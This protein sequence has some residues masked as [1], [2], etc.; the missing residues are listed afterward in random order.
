MQL[1]FVEKASIRRDGSLVELVTLAVNEVP[2]QG[3]VDRVEERSRFMC[4]ARTAVSMK[5][6][7]YGGARQLHVIEPPPKVDSF[8]EGSA[9]RILID[10][11]CVNDMRAKPTADPSNYA[12]A[13]FNF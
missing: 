2:T 7:Y 13:F 3:G 5:Q 10:S 11:V 8:P 1:Y 9:W 12:D 6:L 4:N